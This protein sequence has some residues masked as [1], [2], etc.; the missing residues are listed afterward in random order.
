[1]A[2]LVAGCICAHAELQHTSS[3]GSCDVA[4]S[5]GSGVWPGLKTRKCCLAAQKTPKGTNPYCTRDYQSEKMLQQR[6]RFC[7][8]YTIEHFLLFIFHDC[9][10]MLLIMRALPCPVI[11]C[12]VISR[13]VISPPCP[14]LGLHYFVKMGQ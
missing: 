4:T 1:M 6:F 3:W 14:V 9:K 11:T 12:S 13:R 5:E 2:P 10:I 7:Y 8:K